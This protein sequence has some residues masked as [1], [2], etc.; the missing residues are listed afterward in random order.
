[1]RVLF[2]LKTPSRESVVLCEIHFYARCDLSSR[3]V[4]NLDFIHLSGAVSGA[5]HFRNAGWCCRIAANH[6]TNGFVVGMFASRRK[7]V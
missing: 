3:F 4:Y 7:V 1:M 6:R 2:A 5:A